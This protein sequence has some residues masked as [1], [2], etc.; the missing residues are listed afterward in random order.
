MKTPI[1]KNAASIPDVTGGYVVGS[2]NI[3]KPDLPPKQRVV[4]EY[5]FIHQYSFNQSPEDHIFILA[6]EKGYSATNLRFGHSYG[7][8]TTESLW[9]FNEWM[10][11]MPRKI[12]AL[13][14]KPVKL[15]IDWKG[16]LPYSKGEDIR[17]RIPDI[18]RAK[19]KTFRTGE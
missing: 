12:F 19:E 11:E 13:E 6:G 16:R 18:K 10:T 17:G 4:A 3:I 1:V 9:E 8:L 2:I 15:H 14:D 5:R 7:Y